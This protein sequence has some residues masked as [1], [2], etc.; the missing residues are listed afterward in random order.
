[1]LFLKLL[2]LV[3]LSL[4]SN[5]AV[6]VKGALTTSSDKITMIIDQTF[7]IDEA[8][9]NLYS[10]GLF[11]NV[12]LNYHE[13]D[14]IV[15]VE[16]KKTIS[17]VFFIVDGNKKSKEDLFPYFDQLS[18][19][20]NLKPGMFFDEQ[21]FLTAK[22]NLQG[23][24]YAQ[25]YAHPKITYKLVPY[26]D[27]MNQKN[28]GYTLYV[29]I[30]RGEQYTIDDVEF[31]GLQNL[32]SAELNKYITPRIKN[33][34]IFQISTGPEFLNLQQDFEEI[35][36]YAR[37]Q[38]FLKAKV[39]NACV[40][41][42]KD[43]ENDLRQKIYINFDEGPLCEFRSVGIKVDGVKELET[44]QALEGTANE[45]KIYD[46]Q[47]EIINQYKNHGEQVSVRI[48][49]T[50]EGNQVDLVYYVTPLVLKN[51]ISKIIVK[52]NSA[53]RSNVILK[54][55]KLN[56]GNYFDRTSIHN[57]KRRIMN[58]GFF[59]FVHVQHELDELSGGNIVTIYVEDMPSGQMGVQGSIALDTNP[60]YFF[61]AF[62]DHPNHLG[63]GNQTSVN[64]T[65]GN[66]TLEAGASHKIRNIFN[67]DIDWLVGA[68]YFKSGRSHDHFK[69]PK[70]SDFQKLLGMKEDNRYKGYIT[71][72]V[73]I[74]YKEEGD[75]KKTKTSLKDNDTTVGYVKNVFNFNTGFNF[76]L[77]DYGHISTIV[78]LSNERFRHEEFDDK[79][80]ISRFFKED[81]FPKNRKLAKFTFIHSMG[82]TYHTKQGISLH[83]KLTI[84]VDEHNQ[85]IKY[86]PKAAFYYPLN[87]SQSVYL[88]S[89]I[90]YGHMRPFTEKYY[91]VDNFQADEIYVRGFEQMGPVERN[92]YTPIGGT[93]KFNTYSELIMPFIIPNKALSSFVGVYCG[94]LWGTHMPAHRV[95]KQYADYRDW[96]E[97]TLDIAGQHFGLKTSA[98]A[99]IKLALGPLK[100][101]LSLSAIFSHHQETDQIQMFKFRIYM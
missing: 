100:L 76:N 28:N 20:S 78:N 61:T 83:N 69:T 36:E 91:W 43:E 87:R 93:N 38:G 84:G 40:E 55:S 21:K 88:N 32:S 77:F 71:Y 7:D 70:K 73:D 92:R 98:S 39:K 53:T 47:K 85:Y 29:Y 30:N 33:Y 52:G 22:N 51:V 34:I 64:F 72:P 75:T 79:A 27:K 19:I 54:A 24:H 25:N 37:D 31:I 74:T 81:W 86:E 10:S 6:I 82:K 26:E 4:K 90:S 16:E 59:K 12:H 46:Y 3:L 50:I 49:K 67:T 17:E 94:A 2:F 13:G 97:D 95:L 62:Y 9:E 96:D 80:N 56:V 15:E 44:P 35:E 45:Y 89:S 68:N 66:K 63:T 5:S 48:E 18:Q 14:Y 57:A 65:W 11:E 60:E 41:M 1:M 99:G 23:Y 101:E 8:K 58:L 42:V